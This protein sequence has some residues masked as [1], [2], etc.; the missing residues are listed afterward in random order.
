MRLFKN[1][2]RGSFPHSTMSR[3]DYITVG[4]V[5]LCILAI[6][7]LVYKMTDLFSGDKDAEKTEIAADTVE[8]DDGLIDY[9]IQEDPDSTTAAPATPSSKPSSP[10][11]TTQKELDATSSAAEDDVAVKKDTP[12]TTTDP[13]PSTS[14]D[15]FLV[16]AGSFKQKS[17]AQQ[18]VQ[19]LQK[20][21]YKNAKVELFDRG[22]LAVVLVDRFDNMAEAERVVKDLKDDKVNAYVK[23]KE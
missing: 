16:I 11:T 22:S 13:A 20:L 1:N 5:A 8:V 17:G 2:L 23:R 3:L 7:F 15:N 12:P 6:V 10:A 21:G 4:I 14:S 19:R 18:E 9:T